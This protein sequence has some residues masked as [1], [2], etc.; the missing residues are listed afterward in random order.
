MLFY[1]S[2]EERKRQREEAAKKKNPGIPDLSDPEA[3]QKFFLQE[4]ELGEELLQTGDLEQGLYHLSNAVVI[5]PSPQ[6][7]LGVMQQ[8]LPAPVFQLLLSQLP[9]ANEVCSLY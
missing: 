5:C 7:L 9:A 3:M 8:S 2:I 6:Q 1:Y 4:L